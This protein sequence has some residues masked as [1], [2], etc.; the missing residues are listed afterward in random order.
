MA[1]SFPQNLL[2]GRKYNI[3][4]EDRTVM[5][6]LGESVT[7]KLYFRFLVFQNGRRIADSSLVLND[8]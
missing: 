5:G 4:N 7:N 8:L 3:R 6:I 1:S 2:G